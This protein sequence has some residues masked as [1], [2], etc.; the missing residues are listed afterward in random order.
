MKKLPKIQTMTSRLLLYIKLEIIAKRFGVSKYIKKKL[1]FK[2]KDDL[3]INCKDVE[4]LCIE[5][6]FGNKNLMFYRPPNVQIELFEK[7]LKY[8]FSI[9]R[10]SNKIQD[11]V[12]DL[13]LTF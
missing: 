7:I 8:V 6:L 12:E 9:T 4:S 1:N 11:N 3:I 13:T 5:I 10:N 2:I